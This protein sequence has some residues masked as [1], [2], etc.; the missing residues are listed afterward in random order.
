MITIIL[1][2]PKFY[3]VSYKINPW[4]TK[5]EDKIPSAWDEWND[6]KLTIEKTGAN[7]DLIEPKEECPDMVFLDC[8]VIINNGEEFVLSNFKFSE[9][10]LE[11]KYFEEY[12]SKKFKIRYVKHNFEGHGDSLWVNEKLLLMGYG[13]RTSLE[14]VKE[15]ETMIIDKTVKVQPLKLI[16]ENFY[17]L[18]TCLCPLNK[19]KLVIIYPKAFDNSSLEWIYGNF[20]NIIEATEEE[21]KDFICNMLVINDTIIMP[22]QK[23]N[24]TRSVLKLKEYGFKINMVTMSSFMKAGG[25][26]KCLSFPLY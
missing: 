1:C 17:H 13:I 4:M 7:V 2:P 10:K 26:C 11:T 6:L 8:G 16:D 19:G 25:A 22:R 15:I 23:S 3:K 12:F 5:F 18:D 24:N 9:R 21:A 14:A 20:E